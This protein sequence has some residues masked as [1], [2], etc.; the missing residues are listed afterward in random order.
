LKIDKTGQMALASVA[1]SG[2][3]A[4]GGAL[5]ALGLALSRGFAASASA[6]ADD[7]FSVEVCFEEE[8]LGLFLVADHH[9]VLF[10]DAARVLWGFCF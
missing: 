7:T 5:P 9:L 8:A 6:A 3:V 1:R 4:A 10:F 2:W